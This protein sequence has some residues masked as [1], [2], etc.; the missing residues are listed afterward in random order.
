MVGLSSLSNS[1]GDL[2]CPNYAEEELRPRR[3]LAMVLAGDLQT[4]PRLSSVA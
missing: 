4:K 3:L 1:N 2:S